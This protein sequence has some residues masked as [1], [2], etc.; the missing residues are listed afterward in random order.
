MLNNN[1]FQGFYRI[2]IKP[3][4]SSRYLLLFKTDFILNRN[5][6][7]ILP[8]FPKPPSPSGTILPSAIPYRVERFSRQSLHYRKST[9]M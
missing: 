6:G 7:T 1:I 4:S 5:T 8:S 3:A 2:F 9:N